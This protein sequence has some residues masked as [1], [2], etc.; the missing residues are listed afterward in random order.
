[1]RETGLIAAWLRYDI[2]WSRSNR[3]SNFNQ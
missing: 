2:C 1:L 3:I